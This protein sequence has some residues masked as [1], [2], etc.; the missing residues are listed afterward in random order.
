MDTMSYELKSI[1]G[2]RGVL[3]LE[4]TGFLYAGT[5]TKLSECFQTIPASTVR[6]LLDFSGVQYVSAGAWNQ[7]LELQN[8]I[9]T[10]GGKL[11]L[12]GLKPEVQDGFEFMELNHSL[13]TFPGRMPG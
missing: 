12:Y 6:L 13:K 5:L 9:N 10:A 3:C 7:I 1:P 11:V 4:L 8:R 2:I